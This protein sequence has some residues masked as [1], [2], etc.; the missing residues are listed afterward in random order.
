MR[1][2]GDALVE[3]D[4]VVAVVEN[5]RIVVDVDD[6]D[7]DDEVAEQRRLPAVLR[8]YVEPVMIFGFPVQF[9]RR[10]QVEVRRF[11]AR[12]RRHGQFE[13]ELLVPAHDLVVGRH[14]VV[15]GVA[16]RRRVQDDAR[17]GVGAFG[18]RHLD[19][20]LGEGRRVVVNVHHQDAHFD[21]VRRLTGQ[22]DQ[23]E[24]VGC[25]GLAV[26]HHGRHDLAR[27]PV[28]P[29]FARILVESVGEAGLCRDDAD[30][31]PSR[32][33]LGH[34]QLDSHIDGPRLHQLVVVLLA[35]TG[36]GPLSVHHKGLPQDEQDECAVLPHCGR[37][38]Q[39]NPSTATQNP[40]VILNGLPRTAN[41]LVRSAN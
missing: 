31:R 15:A 21:R 14:V 28:Q 37:Y 7:V 23:V 10:L 20:R 29:E 36:A 2:G 17:P 24:S 3:G 27:R 13:F 39:A 6:G 33:L 41:A 19:R 22:D 26:Q 8:R 4:D 18:E 30:H 38:G 35:R 25:Q 5:G 11:A 32:P 16:I 1:S 40:L 12:V 34:F 9:A